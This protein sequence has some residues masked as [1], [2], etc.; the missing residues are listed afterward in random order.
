MVGKGEAMS[1]T[2]RA[3]LIAEIEVARGKIANTGTALREAGE[4]MRRRFDIPNRAKLSFEKHRPA[5][6]GGAAILGLLL[7]KLPARKK[8]VF[9]GQATGAVGKI[10]T[11]LGLVKFAG[12]LAK[13]FLGDLAAKWLASRLQKADDGQV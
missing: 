10:G 4:G 13:P 6:L 5:W 11:I 7:A 12:G 8:T 2:E 1:D 3:A 9:V